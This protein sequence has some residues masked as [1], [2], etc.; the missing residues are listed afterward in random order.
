MQSMD[1]LAF[2]QSLMY[3]WFWRLSPTAEDFISADKEKA[4][5]NGRPL[6]YPVIVGGLKKIKCSVNN[7]LNENLW[8]LN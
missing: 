5:C 6:L 4:K 3:T 7:C 1:F 2:M 8:F